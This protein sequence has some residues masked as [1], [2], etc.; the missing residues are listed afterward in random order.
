MFTGCM[1][2]CDGVDRL[3]SGRYVIF[4]THTRIDVAG[5]KLVKDLVF[6]IRF[7]TTYSGQLDAVLNIYN[8]QGGNE[9][10]RPD[11][12]VNVHTKLEVTPG[13]IP[14]AAHVFEMG[15]GV[16]QALLQASPEAQE[17]QEDVLLPF[18]AILSA[19]G[20]EI[21]RMYFSVVFHLKPKVKTTLV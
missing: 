16:P 9:N 10:P 11:A 15:V 5:P 12:T 2:L 20:H 7:M 6:Y 4:G 19:N 21:A 3:S 1:I 17:L 13:R 8:R 14:D 18:D